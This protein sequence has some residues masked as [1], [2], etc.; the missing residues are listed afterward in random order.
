MSKVLITGH[1]R[2]GTGYT[3]KLLQSHGIDVGHEVHGTEGIV[4]WPHI[5]QGH[6]SWIGD[7]VLEQYDQ[8]VHQVRHPLQVISS[9]Q[10]MKDEAFEYMFSA[11]GHPGGERGLRWYMWSWLYWNEFVEQFAD[12]RFQVEEVDSVLPDLLQSFEK[13]ERA[14]KTAPAP[15]ENSREHGLY[16]WGDLKA[17]DEALFRLIL[18]KAEEYGYKIEIP[19]I[20]VCMM[21]L[22]DGDVEYLPQCLESIAPL[23]DQ[24]VF[25]NTQS[26]REKDFPDDLLRQYDAEVYEHPWEK[27]FSLHR[28]QSLSYARGDWVFLI[29]CDEELFGDIEAFKLFLAELPEHCVCVKFLMS[30]VQ[31]GTEAMRFNTAKCFR[32]GYIHYRSIVHNQ[33]V[34]HGTGINNDDV[35]IQHYGYDLDAEG[36]Q[37]KDERTGTLLQKRLE[38]DPEDYQARFYLAQT[39]GQSGDSK[40]CLHHALQYIENKDKVIGWNGSIYATATQAAANVGDMDKAKEI[41]FQGLEEIPTDLDLNYMAAKLAVEEG[42]VSALMKYGQQYLDTFHAYQQDPSV[43]KERFTYTQKPEDLAAILFHLGFIY[44][45]KAKNHW[46]KLKECIPESADQIIE[47]A[48]KEI[49]VDFDAV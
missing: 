20:S 22:Q 2:S 11:I 19:S 1:G 27:N 47:N 32:R 36:K 37:V 17:E 39:A 24:L 7:V 33:P 34:I 35:Y 21:G 43:Q 40:T 9:A 26:T 4:S 5:T 14:G 29:D 23:A 38:E 10:T 8:I 13:K 46:A 15:N 44:A 49:G 12:W 45:Q 16:T 31:Q 42:R 18:A 3:A 28:N 30:D 41:L 48:K 25:V 6:L